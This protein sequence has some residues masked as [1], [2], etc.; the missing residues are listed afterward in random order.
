MS[1]A[2]KQQNNKN[3][4][5]HLLTTKLQEAMLICKFTEEQTKFE[6]MQNNPFAGSFSFAFPTPELEPS[7]LYKKDALVLYN[8]LPCMDLAS[9]HL[10]VENPKCGV[11]KLCIYSWERIPASKINLLKLPGTKLILTYYNRKM[12]RDGLPIYRVD[13][14]DLVEIYPP[15]EPN[16]HTL[17]FEKMKEAGRVLFSASHFE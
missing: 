17:T 13:N 2:E 3:K 10:L 11:E 14:S 16:T 8:L 15:E 1:V 12:A 4:E 5:E 6:E 7:N 9:K